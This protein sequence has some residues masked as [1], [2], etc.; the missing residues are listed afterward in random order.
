MT[1]SLISLGESPRPL[2]KR[3]SR[4]K[5]MWARRPES[6]ANRST[7]AGLNTGLPPDFIL[8]GIKSL[9]FTAARKFDLTFEKVFVARP[10]ATGLTAASRGLIAAMSSGMADVPFPSKFATRST[11]EIKSRRRDAVSFPLRLTAASRS[12]SVRGLAGRGAE[13]SRLDFL[14]MSLSS[15]REFRAWPRAVSGGQGVTGADIR[16]LYHIAD[17]GSSS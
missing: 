6:R 16:E 11:P 1:S 5:P 10:A 7:Q 12:A 17:G 4:L 13:V 9:A 14:V 8:T 2:A 3:A 15:F